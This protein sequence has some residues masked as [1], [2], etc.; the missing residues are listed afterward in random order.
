MPVIAIIAQGAMGAGLARRLTEH[1]ATVLTSLAGRSA[2]SAQRAAAAGMRAVDDAAL[3]EAD[4]ILSVLPPAEAMALA[5]RLAPV[6]AAAPRKPLYADCNA[7]S[8]DQAREIGE[9]IA[10]TGAPFVDGGIIG[11]PPSTDGYTPTLYIAGSEAPRLLS[12]NDLGLKLRLIEGPIGAASG[13]KLCYASITKGFA[14]L[15]YASILAATRHGAAAAL[16]AELAASQPALL[17]WLARFIPT[18][19]DKAWRFEGEMAEIAAF[20]G[21]DHAEA[22]IYQGAAGLYHRLAADRAGDSAEIAA[23]EAFFALPR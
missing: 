22:G 14:A 11:G 8:P 10:A 3:A 7:I 13:L 20:L 23:M 2:A 6:L 4:I 21:P 12:L 18:T 16:Q 5:T 19:Y 1:G 17:A 9:V 15:G